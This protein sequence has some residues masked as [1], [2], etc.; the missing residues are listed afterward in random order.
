VDQSKTGREIKIARRRKKKG[1][2]SKRSEYTK[3]DGS[4]V[5]MDSTWEVA[6]ARKL[7]ELG[8][9]WERD[10]NRKLW[11][12][13]PAGRRR[14]YIPDF[15]LPDLDMYIEVKG[16]WTDTARTKMKDV[17]MRYPGKI[18][19]LESLEEI[20]QVKSIVATTGSLSIDS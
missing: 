8:I 11:Y 1:L 2:W 14:N 4:V 17:V 12:F 3:A 13:T 19:I 10:T 5:I 7:D 6:M 20:S 16:Y 15:Y 18:C 9:I